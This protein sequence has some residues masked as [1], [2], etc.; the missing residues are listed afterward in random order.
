MSQDHK[1]VPDGHLKKC[2]GGGKGE[3]V[4][5]DQDQIV[6]GVTGWSKECKVLRERN[7]SH[8]GLQAGGGSVKFPFLR[9]AWAAWL[10]NIGS[11]NN[12]LSGYGLFTPSLSSVFWKM[13]R[14]N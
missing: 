13:R 14:E 5:V 6:Q 4:K 7:G 8:R 10:G 11:L 9:H 12:S 3:E 2:E 1:E